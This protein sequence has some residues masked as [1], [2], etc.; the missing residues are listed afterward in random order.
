MG[1]RFSDGFLVGALVG[2]AAVFLL[3]TKKGNKVLQAITEEGIAGLSE[4]VEEM[5]EKEVIPRAE[6]KAQEIVEEVKEKVEGKLESELNA[7]PKPK[8]FFR[9]K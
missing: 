1:G 4:L 5:E 8:R 6:K 3:G 9:K 7:V 2:G